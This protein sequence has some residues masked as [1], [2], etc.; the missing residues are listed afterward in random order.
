[1]RTPDQCV[2]LI[3]GLGTR[4]LERTAP[5]P[6]PLL[7][8]GNRPFLDYL[9]AEAARF[10]FRQILLL[11]GY[12]AD[13]VRRYLSDSNVG[14]RLGLNITLLVEPERAGTGGALWH[15]RDHLQKCFYLLNGDSWFD[16]NWLALTQVEGPSAAVGTIALRWLSEPGR[17]GAVELD[18]SIVRRFADHAEPGHSGYSNA[19]V[20]LFSRDIVDHLLPK[21]SLEKDTFPKL[22]RMGCLCASGFLGRFI[23]IG[24]PAD[25]E[26][27]G[28]SVPWWP[29][30]PAAFLD[31]DGTLNVD[32]GYV[33]SPDSFRWLPGAPG[34]VKSLNDAGVYVFVVTN[35]AGVAR[36]LYAESEV[37]E[38]H[39]W[40]QS[41]L[42]DL[43]AHIDDFRFCPYH[44]EGS[45][46]SYRR[47]DPWRKPK[48]GML[49]DL[50]QHWP[51]DPALSAVIGD[52]DSDIE[53]GHVL[54]IRGIKLKEG[55]IEA[56]VDELLKYT[57]QPG[58]PDR[59]QS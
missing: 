51:V 56:A 21:C 4:L 32:T 15:A 20:Y 18:G 54:G 49:Y 30:R 29:R 36:G 40:M 59:S 52:K 58:N 50:M 43:G 16:F 48:P 26:K 37:F 28:S 35:Q 46:E 45:V 39:D 22:A 24:I 17:Y 23:D 44:P 6:K 34:A 55:N 2:I 19:G 57:Q 14:D 7:R 27:A 33:H 3:G 12:R 11:A 41:E 8:V 5:T 25:F 31:R 1:M 10:G 53:A 38:L 13:S 47:D 42:R 9:L